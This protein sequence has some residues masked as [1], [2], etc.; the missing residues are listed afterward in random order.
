MVENLP[1]S[2]EDAGLIHG[3]RRSPGEGNG[4]PLQY[5]CRK[6]PLDGGAWRATGHAVAESQTQLS[7]STAAIHFTV[8]W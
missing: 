5:S 8:T 1:A 2:T 7:D 4:N 3:L 6:S